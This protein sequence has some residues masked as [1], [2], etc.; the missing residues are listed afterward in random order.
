M[1]DGG[2]RLQINYVEYDGQI[3]TMDSTNTYFPDKTMVPLVYDAQQTIKA[4]TLGAVK[5]YI[6]PNEPQVSEQRFR[7]IGGDFV[8][9][10]IATEL[11][12]YYTPYETLRDAYNVK[13]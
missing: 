7:Y 4:N 10:A 6:N 1:T 5:W 9:D 11:L 3:T 8:L 2:A 12:H 13:A